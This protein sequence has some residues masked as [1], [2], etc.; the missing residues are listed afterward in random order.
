[1][2][3]RPASVAAADFA[4]AL[5]TTRSHLM[6]L[7]TAVGT[8][9]YFESCFAAARLRLAFDDANQITR[10]LPACQRD[11]AQHQLAS[12]RSIAEPMLALAPVLSR[13]EIRQLGSSDPGVDLCAWQLSELQWRREVL[14][15]HFRDIR[16]ITFWLPP[17]FDV[18]RK[19][20]NQRSLPHDDDST[21]A[22]AVS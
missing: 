4:V 10:R 22:P 18:P 2:S 17:A 5:H 1:V 21:T 11:R 12:L 7:T 20:T 14:Q 15:I 8:A 16:H 3:E 19:D 13:E 9:S 6:I